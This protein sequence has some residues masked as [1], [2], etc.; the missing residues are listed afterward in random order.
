MAVGKG[1]GVAVGTSVGSRTGDGVAVGTGIAV[2]TAAVTMKTVLAVT[3]ATFVLT[4]CVPT[5]SE[6]TRTS[7]TKVPLASVAGIGAGRTST[8]PMF[9]S[10][11]V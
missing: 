5:G 2:G 3:P 7:V 6:G 8:F 11:T 10:N 4:T 9:N 1:V